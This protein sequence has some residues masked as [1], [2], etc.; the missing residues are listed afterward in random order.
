MVVEGATT[1]DVFIKYLQEV[2]SCSLEPGDI[3][4]M[5]NLSSHKGNEV[6]EIIESRGASIKYLPP[7]SPELN[8]IEMMWSKVKNFLK[9]AKARTK[10]DLY[11]KIGEAL[12][13]VTKQDAF[14]WFK[15]CGYVTI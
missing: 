13:N 14:G 1:R 5:D 9:D 12:E 8:P 2:L 15:H 11:Q 10:E 6:R 4:I 3:V 7:Y